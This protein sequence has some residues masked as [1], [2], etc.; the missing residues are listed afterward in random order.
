MSRGALTEHATPCA[1]PR[2]CAACAPSVPDTSGDAPCARC[3][4]AYDHHDQETMPPRREGCDGFECSVDHD[5][6]RTPC[7]LRGG[8]VTSPPLS[9]KPCARCGCTLVFYTLGMEPRPAP[10]GDVFCGVC[11]GRAPPRVFQASTK[12]PHS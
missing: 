2:A 4:A 12:G 11:E 7:P 3:G 10:A 8:A 6:A 1:F 9:T 5:E